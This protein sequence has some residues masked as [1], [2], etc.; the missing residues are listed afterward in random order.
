[1]INL[2]EYLATII[3]ISGYI[4]GLGAVT[5]IDLHGFLAQ[6]SPYWTR[7]TITAHKITKPLIWLGTSLALIGSVYSLS[8]EYTTLALTHTLIFIPLVLN[9]IFLTFV[10]SPLL[11]KKEQDGMAE[12]ILPSDIQLKIKVSFVVSVLGWWS[13]LF[14]YIYNLVL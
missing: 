13:S 4:I 1:M 8:L 5:V 12:E 9:G 3:T 6:K 2:S 10:V 14:L 7:A 11:L